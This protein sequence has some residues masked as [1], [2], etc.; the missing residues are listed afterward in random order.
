MNTLAG[1]EGDVSE[2]N[3]QS[4]EVLKPLS[5]LGIALDPQLLALPSLAPI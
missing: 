3:D 4:P 2:N 5:A 1:W